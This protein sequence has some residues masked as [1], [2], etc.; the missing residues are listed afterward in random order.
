MLLTVSYGLGRLMTSSSRDHKVLGE[1]GLAMTSFIAQTD[2]ALN[3]AFLWLSHHQDQGHGWSRRSFWISH[4]A[5][6]LLAREDGQIPIQDHQVRASFGDTAKRFGSIGRFLYPPDPGSLQH[7]ANDTA[8]VEA[9]I[10]QK[11]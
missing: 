4:Q 5:N 6:D 10:D 8:D 11:G 7:V 1:K 2:G 9:L 3:S